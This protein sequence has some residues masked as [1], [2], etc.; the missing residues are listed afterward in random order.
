[1]PPQMLAETLQAFLS[2]RQNEAELGNMA[3]TTT[4]CILLLNKNHYHTMYD[5]VKGNI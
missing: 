1:M 3:A 4:R 2:L 5:S